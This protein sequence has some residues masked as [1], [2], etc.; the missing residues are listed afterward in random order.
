V[1][2]R[3]LADDGSIVNIADMQPQ[4]ETSHC[5]AKPVRLA[6]EM[7]Q[8]WFAKRGLKPGSRIGGEAFAPR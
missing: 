6:L 4:N 5:P 7:N 1:L 8:G 2:F 3:S